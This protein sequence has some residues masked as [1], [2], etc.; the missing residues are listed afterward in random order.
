MK[1]SVFALQDVPGKG[2]GLVATE[3]IPKGTRILSERPLIRVPRDQPE[4]KK[5]FESVLQQVHA[6]DDVQLQAFLSLRNIHKGKTTSEQYMGIIRTN[7]LPI[8]VE[9]SKQESLSMHA[10]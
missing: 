7:G 10:A 9:G 5:L 6:L 3:T 4:S 1:S 8:G 2:K